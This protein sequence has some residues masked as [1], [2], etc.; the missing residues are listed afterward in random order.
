M[1]K[2]INYEDDI[3]SL[4]LLIRGLSDIVKLEIDPEF[5]RDR[6]EGDIRFIDGAIRRIYESLA[7]GPFFVKR[8]EYLK[9]MQ[10]LKRA[11]V[12]LL[13]AILDKRVAFAEYLSGSLENLRQMR[14]VHDRD[15]GDI[16]SSLSQSKGMEQEHIISEDEYKILLS[17]PDD[18]TT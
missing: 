10:R 7:G 9:G 18:T 5:F 8:H 2:K 17:P 15:I 11:F 3:F 1:T 4:S 13:D 14:D 6:I 16:R 12:E